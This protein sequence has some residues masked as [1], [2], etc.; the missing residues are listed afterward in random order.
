[1]NMKEFLTNFLNVLGM[2]WWIEIVTDDPH[3]T[4]YFGPF[5]SANEADAA[6]SGFME[7]LE[8]EGAKNT[9]VIVK[10]CK[11]VSLTI[12]DELGETRGRKNQPTL[13]GQLS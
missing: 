9:S 8:E 1:M 6:K 3:C 13:S 5:A 10:R 7:D 12:D 11:P 4:Y 2:A